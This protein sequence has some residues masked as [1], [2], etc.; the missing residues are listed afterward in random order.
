MKQLVEF[1]LGEEEGVVLIEVEEPVQG[2]SQ[3]VALNPS[4]LAYQASQTFSEAIAKSVKPVAQALMKEVKSLQ[5]PPDEVEVAFGIVMS[6][7]AGA[8]VTVGGNANFC[9]KLKWSCSKQKL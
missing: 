7:E 9:V 2:A 6:M 5:D 3:R 8:V 4:K 1:Q